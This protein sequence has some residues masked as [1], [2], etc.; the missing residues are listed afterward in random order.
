M[1]DWDQSMFYLHFDGAI[2]HSNSINLKGTYVDLYLEEKTDPFSSRRS[3]NVRVRA[4]DDGKNS[5]EGRAAAV[6]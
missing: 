5:R 4:M 3:T 1:M 6:T 2:K